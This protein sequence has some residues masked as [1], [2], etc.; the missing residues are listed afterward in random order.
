M[1]AYFHCGWVPNLYNYACYE[2]A[3]EPD[4]DGKECGDDGCGYVCGYCPITKF[5]N[6]KLQCVF[7]QGMCGDIDYVGVCEDNLVKWC[8]NG[9]LQ[10]FDCISLGPTWQCGWFEEGGYYWCLQ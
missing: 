7:G 6:D 5:C 10:Q 3:C 4:C 1:G 8:Q 9:I 2:E